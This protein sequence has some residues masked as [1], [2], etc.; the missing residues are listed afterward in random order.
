MVNLNCHNKNYTTIQQYRIGMLKYIH[1][2]YD[3]KTFTE[4]NVLF[5]YYLNDQKTMQTRVSKKTRHNNMNI[6]QTLGKQL[7]NRILVCI[8]FYD[9]D[10]YYYVSMLRAVQYVL[11]NRKQN[12][13]N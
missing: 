12:D 2:R 9:Y 7:D 8:A 6:K 10:A 11:Q 5:T 4:K 1:T 13:Y 3:L